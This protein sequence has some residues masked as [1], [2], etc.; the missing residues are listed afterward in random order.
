MIRD[1]QIR[2]AAD[3]LFY[4][5]R[6]VGNSLLAAAGEIL[7]KEYNIAQHPTCSN[8]AASAAVYMPPHTPGVPA[9]KR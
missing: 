3:E 4:K 2:R 9:L 6:Y 1:T 8:S 7:L 5:G